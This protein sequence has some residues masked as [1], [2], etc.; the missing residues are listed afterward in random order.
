MIPRIISTILILTIFFI[1]TEVGFGADDK[2]TNGKII[3]NTA[4]AS[5]DTPSGEHLIVESSPTGNSKAGLGQGT[6]TITIVPFL[7]NIPSQDT[8]TY[9]NTSAQP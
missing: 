7:E 5:F 3:I 6:P 2:A 8:P 4:T 9:S 1:V